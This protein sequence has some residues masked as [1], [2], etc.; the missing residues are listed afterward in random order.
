MQLNRATDPE[1]IEVTTKIARIGTWKCKTKE[2]LVQWSDEVYEIHDEYLGKDISMDD[3]IMYYQENYRSIVK[4]SIK[5]AKELKKPWDFEAIIVSAKQREIWV[6]S[7]GYPIF[8]NNELI[9]IR[10]AFLDIDK[11]KRSQSQLEKGKSVFEQIFDNAQVLICLSEPNGRVQKVSN[12]VHTLLGY[13]VSEVIGMDRL[14]LAHPS[15]VKHIKS[16]SNLQLNTQNRNSTTIEYRMQHKEGHYLWFITT[17]SFLKN[18]TSEISGILTT[19]IEITNRR[20]LED[21][22]SALNAELSYE[23]KKNSKSLQNATIQLNQQ[24]AALDKS[25][26]VSILNRDLEFVFVNELFIQVTGFDFDQIKGKPISYLKLNSDADNEIHDKWKQLSQG[27]SW[28]GEIRYRKSDNSTLWMKSTISPFKDAAGNIV[29]YVCIDFDITESKRMSEEL[30][31]Q[32]KELIAM[33]A[34]LAESLEKEK[35]LSKLKSS[36]VATASHQFRT[37]LTVI[38][39]S[40]SIL[41]MQLAQMDLDPKVTGKVDAVYDRV[42]TQVRKMTE[43]MNEVLILGKIENKG[44]KA[45]PKKLDVK[46]FL[47]DLI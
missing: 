16:E 40:M 20:V 24:V 44:V 35:E 26:L 21:R 10:G 17:T 19:S 18:D 30:K 23:L 1:I 39:S 27:N 28:T 3:A 34:D 5:E 15:D 43:M 38:Q 46:L 12:A 41:Q 14:S 4:R 22:I 36:F 31:A 33:Q 13:E 37:P 8:N 32:A 11:F 29:K 25:A 9:E 6:R 42:Q 45:K 47:E 7:L 2:R